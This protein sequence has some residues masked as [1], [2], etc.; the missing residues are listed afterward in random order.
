MHEENNHPAQDDKITL[1]DASPLTPSIRFMACTRPVTANTV[2]KMP[3]GPHANAKSIPGTSTR[4]I[5][6][7]K[8][9]MPR[10][11]AIAAI[12]SLMRGAVERQK[13]PSIRK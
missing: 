6:I 9:E 7:P 8:T 2:N 1:P 10:S 5:H 13:L 4:S 12:A 11:V 3:T